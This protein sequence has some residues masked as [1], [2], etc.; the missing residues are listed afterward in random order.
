MAPD[1]TE[2]HDELLG[3]REFLERG[4]AL[5]AG[6]GV[7]GRTG[8]THIRH[9]QDFPLGNETIAASWS[10]NDGVLR[11]GEVFERATGGRLLVSEA[12]FAIV[13]ADGTRLDSTQMRVVGGP[14]RETIAATRRSARAAGRLSGRRLT[15]TLE[16]DPHPLLPSPP[17]ATHR[18]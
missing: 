8:I 15:V 2:T 9:G 1:D 10:V 11:A 16:D 13:L 17:P 6:L 3:R 5:A 14:V 7:F 18:R 4:A 12:V